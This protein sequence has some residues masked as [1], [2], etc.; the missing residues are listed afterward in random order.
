[1]TQNI[2]RDNDEIDLAELFHALW[3]H[4]ISIGFCT[5]FA[6]FCAGYYALTTD[7]EYTAKS[8]FEIQ[9]GDNG[10]GFNLPDDL[11]ALASLAGVQGGDSSGTDAL[12]ERVKSKEYIL[13]TNDVLN[14]D[15]DPY[16]ND[17]APNQTDPLWKATIKNLI[18]W[19]SDER[20]ADAII[21]NKIFETFKEVVSVSTTD[22]G[23]I[24]LSVTHENPERAAF[25]ANELMA[26]TRDLVLDEQEE[27]TDLRLNYLSETLADALQEMER[28]Q[29]RL[30]LYALENSTVA[31]QSF[32]AG[33]LQLDQLRSER[34]DALEFT[35]TLTRLEEIV[36]FG[37][38]DQ[39]AYLTLR[40]TNPMIDDVRFRRI[41]GMSET[42]SAWSWP[43]LETIQA[44][45]ATL[46]DR[47]QRLNI[48]IAEIEVDARQYASSA[49]EFAQLTREAKIAEATYT[50]LIEQVK[51]QSLAAGFKP[52]AFKV[53]EY[54]TPP[55]T[56]SAPKR[57]L[58]LALGAVLG[59]F[60]GSALALMN[61]M[62]RG[63]YYSRG[64][65]ITDVCA[66]L[67][68]PVSAL[69]RLSKLPLTVI[70]DR[71][72]TRN[73]LTLDELLMLT[74]NQQLIF[75]ANLN[76]RTDPAGIARAIAVRASTTGRK[77]AL[78]DFSGSS[79][80][81]KSGD[82]EMSVLDMPFMAT[83]ANV[84]LMTSIPA[85]S[86]PNFYLSSTLTKRMN[87]LFENYDQVILCGG[88]ADPS[89]ALMGIKEYDPCVVLLARSKHTKKSDVQKIRTTQPI[90]VLLYE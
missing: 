64:S 6:I 50:V 85:L 48:E 84:H 74:A 32:V 35:T 53:Y 9:Q 68:L 54:A 46:A 62:R 80:E 18:G 29:E 5:A 58:I 23:A 56:P 70:A 24:S 3:A 87:A 82:E 2:T 59:V 22:A 89:S 65:I 27:S 33:S 44:V 67:V 71:L 30:K 79:A 15:A 8:V 16:F 10:R 37:A 75:V 66:K 36:K 51:S 26:F 86:G 39:N 72:N 7:K 76:T 42:I 25:Y 14:F 90:E 11:G 41:M 73:I 60:V 78:C 63:V 28:T 83:N 55:L 88:D 77:I 57:S 52:D 17:Y 12:L 20:T 40:D 47:V 43:E 4:K 19:Q 1:M 21:E 49:E 61:S 81:Q 31:N 45:S 34:Q 69:R 13:E 38:L